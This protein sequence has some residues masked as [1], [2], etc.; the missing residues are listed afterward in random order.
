MGFSQ[1]PCVRMFP[2]GPSLWSAFIV[3]SWILSNAVFVSI[4]MIVFV[5]NCINMLY[6]MD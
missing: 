4:E 5:L 6:Y 2:L 1:T 3:T